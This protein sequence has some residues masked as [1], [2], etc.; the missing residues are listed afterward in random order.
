MRSI[1]APRVRTRVTMM[2]HQIF[3]RISFKPIKCRQIWGLEN[4]P[5]FHFTP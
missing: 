5:L 2:L 1:T 3:G 4:N